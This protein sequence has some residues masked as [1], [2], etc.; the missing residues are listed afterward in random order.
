[1]TD[2]GIPAMAPGALTPVAGKVEEVR[3]EAALGRL[4]I[5]LP[6][7][8]S[9]LEQ[10]QRTRMRAGDLMRDGRKL[11]APLRFGDNWIGQIMSERLRTVAVDKDG[12]V[13]PVL[14]QFHE[15]LDSVEAVV[16]LAA[17]LYRTTDEQAAGE[18][19]RAAGRIG[20]Q[21]GQNGT[22]P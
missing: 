20:A 5:D 19:H 13:S 3:D 17:G 6:A 7:A 15:L 18:L 21:F 4:R 11:D 10:I 8:E 16:R 12:G 14:R 2:S 9:L 22:Q 1:M